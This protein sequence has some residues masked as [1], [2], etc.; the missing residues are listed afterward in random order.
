MKKKKVKD[1][2]GILANAEKYL[3]RGNFQLALKNFETAQKK[4]KRDDI[5]AKIAQCRREVKIEKAKEQVKKAFK[6]EKKGHPDKALTYFRAANEVLNEAWILKRIEKLDTQLTG[7]NAALLAKA[8]EA[9]GDFRKA[10]EY[11]ATACNHTSDDSAGSLGLKRARCL[12]GVKQYVEAVEVFKNLSHKDDGG[13]YDYG[14]ALAQVGRY[15]QCLRVWEGLEVRDDRINEQRKIVVQR[16]CSDMAERLEQSESDASICNDARYLLQ[17]A[18]DLLLS[19]QRESIERLYQYG[20]LAWIKKLWEAEEWQSIADILKNYNG[21]L[22]PTLLAL[23]AKV[24]FKMAEADSRHLSTMLLYWL[25]AI[26]S[27]SISVTFAPNSHQQQKVRRKLITMAEDLIKTHADTRYGREALVQLAI[28]NDLMQTL[29]ELLEKQANPMD[30][31]YTPGLSGHLNRSNAVLGLIRENRN[32][33][34]SRQHYLETGAFYS[35]A[36]SCLYQLKY[37]AYEKAAELGADLPKDLEKDEFVAY[38]IKLIYFEY[39]LHCLESGDDQ[40]NDYFQSTP[41]LFEI[42]PTLLQK[43]TQS[44]VNFK[45]WSLLQPYEDVLALIHKQFPNRSLGKTLS[46]VMSRGAIA[47]FNKGRLNSKVLQ[48][49]MRKALKLDPDN[50]MAKESLQDATINFE[51]QTMYD[52][53]DRHKLGKASKIARESDFDEVRDRYFECIEEAFDQILT[54]DLESQEKMIIINDL[55]EWGTTVDAFQPV[56]DKLK[57]HLNMN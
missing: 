33:F 12:V 2:N 55:F 21:P 29:L 47:N 24:W 40:V 22:T 56:M 46:L 51:V 16:L 7:S 38:A 18:T 17:S 36:G 1:I 13:R 14:F 9:A 32:F 11:Y 45:E 39:G 41:A 35:A 30:L 6:A 54:C 31:L 28:D 43:L 49:R 19:D 8:A 5:A 10:A 53:F 15:A 25:S 34:K 37:Q 4:L 26:Y 3:L 27:P 20:T 50:E 42:A 23:N 48:G 57:M 44:A 52:A